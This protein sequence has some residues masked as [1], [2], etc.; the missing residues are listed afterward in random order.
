MFQ[1]LLVE[2]NQRFRRVLKIELNEWFPSMVVEEAKDGREAMEKVESLC[3][4][5]VLMDIS[6][7]DESG[8][9]LTE[10]LKRKCP[11]TTI[12]MLSTYDL[13]ECR[14]AAIQHGANH[15]FVKGAVNINDIMAWIESFLSGSGKAKNTEEE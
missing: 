15:Y 9:D 14:Q 11:G 6:L 2:D 1:T 13:P 10:K 12:V 5:L 7:P 3:P 8:L 4:T